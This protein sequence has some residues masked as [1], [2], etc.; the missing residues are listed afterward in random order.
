MSFSDNIFTSRNDEDGWLYNALMDFG[1]LD[2]ETLF[3][4]YLST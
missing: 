4:A 1:Q 3:S 2:V